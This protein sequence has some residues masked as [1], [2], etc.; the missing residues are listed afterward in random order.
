MIIN[1][2]SLYL[3][4]NIH[5]LTSFT[6]IICGMFILG[7]ASTSPPKRGD[8]FLTRYKEYQSLGRI[9]QASLNKGEYEKAIDQYSK[10]IEISP[11]EVSNYYYRGLAWYKNGNI[12]KAIADFDRVIMLDARWRSAYIYR[13]LCRMEGGEYRKALKDYKIA[14]NRDSKDPVIHN[15]L[16]W[17]YA[18]AEDEQLRD[19][20]KALEHAKKAVELSHEKNAEI[21]D[22]LAHAY[23][24]NGKIKEAIETEM[25]A[26]NLAPHNEG[27]RENLE[28]YEREM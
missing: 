18:V 10:A 13:G 8:D 20:A 4:R 2:F 3:K 5:S 24:I 12:D 9:G 16:A 25:K 11:F 27:F 6:W 14:L 15:N 23:F 22:T 19:T 1:R 21:L 17:L 26:V 28:S 7:C